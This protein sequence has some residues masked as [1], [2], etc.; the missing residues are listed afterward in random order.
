MKKS[1]S[2]KNHDAGS[3]NEKRG[4]LSPD[5]RTAVSHRTNV[6]GSLF[7]GRELQ[8]A[9]YRTNSYPSPFAVITDERG[10]ELEK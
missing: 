5:N 3:E 7:M 10:Q 9:H 4:T 6:T 1:E 8:K 2:L